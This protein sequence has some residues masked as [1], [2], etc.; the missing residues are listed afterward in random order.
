MS[1]IDLS[2]DGSSEISFLHDLYDEVSDCILDFGISLDAFSE[3]RSPECI[4]A[5]PGCHRQSR[6]HTLQGAGG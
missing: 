1:N 5:H 2:N 6:Y 4:E 3:T